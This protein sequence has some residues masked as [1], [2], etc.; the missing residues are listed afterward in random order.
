MFV[1]SFQPVQTVLV[2]GMAFIVL[3]DQLYSGG[4]VV[5]FHVKIFK[6]KYKKNE[7]KIM[8]R[9]FFNSF[10]VIGATLIMIGLYLVLWGKRAEA[11]YQSQDKEETLTKHLLEGNISSQECPTGVDIPYIYIYIYSPRN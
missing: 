2:A 7:T 9:H 3:G 11:R 1:A 8:F 10:R 4:Y 5:K 6:E